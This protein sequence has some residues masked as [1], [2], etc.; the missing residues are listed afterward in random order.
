[1]QARSNHASACS[2]PGGLPPLLRRCLHSA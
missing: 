2:D 1:M